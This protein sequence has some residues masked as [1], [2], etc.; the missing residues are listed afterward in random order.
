MANQNVPERLNA[1]LQD[2][3]GPF[4]PLTTFDQI[5]M[6]DGVSRWN[7]EAVDPRAVF[8]EDENT[9]PGVP[10]PID[11]DTLGGVPAEN[12]ALKTDSA[13]PA[14]GKTGQVLSKASESNSDVAWTDVSV[15]WD[16][17]KNK[18]N[19]Y[20]PDTHKHSMSDISDATFEEWTFVFSDGTTLVRKVLVDG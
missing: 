14:G 3:H 8:I 20:N 12:Y 2:K 5:I 11:A 6:P 18:P 15:E 13:M 9:L 4:Y 10:A 7:G 17:V 16:G 19:S 1:P